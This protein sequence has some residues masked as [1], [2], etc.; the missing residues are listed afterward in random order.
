MSLALQLSALNQ[1]AQADAQFAEANVFSREPNNRAMK[2]RLLHYRGIH[3]LDEKKP[4]DAELLLG[5]AQ[6]AYTDL[7][8]ARTLTR[9]PAP[10]PVRNHFDINA[11]ITTRTSLKLLGTDP[12][13]SPC[14]LA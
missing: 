1:F 10:K 4:A 3:M 9:E 2:A 13:C 12:G 11:R 5:Q 6:A 14:F 8:P 7:V